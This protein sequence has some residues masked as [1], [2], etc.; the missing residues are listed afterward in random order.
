MH[1]LRLRFFLFFLFSGLRLRRAH[2]IRP[3]EQRLLPFLPN[4]FRRFP[5]SYI[6]TAYICP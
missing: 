2:R 3:V 4:R 1:M 5:S 6:T